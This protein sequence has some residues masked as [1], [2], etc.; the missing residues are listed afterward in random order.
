MKYLI[1]KLVVVF[2]LASTMVGCISLSYTEKN[3]LKYLKSNGIDTAHARGGYDTPNSVWGAGLLNILPGFGNFYLAFGR[4]NDP[5]QGI[6]G[7]FNLLFW[8]ISI[9]WAAPQGAIDAHTLNER[10]MLYFYHY[11]KAGKEEMQR[12]GLQFE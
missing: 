10:E 7:V 1:L 6:Y 12:S 8:P 11:E 3:E 9:V 4:G 2:M 5:V